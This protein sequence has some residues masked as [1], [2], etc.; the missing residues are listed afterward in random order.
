MKSRVV[1]KSPGPGI[2]PGY[3]ECDRWLLLLEKKRKLEPKDIPSCLFVF[4]QQL[5]ILLTTLMSE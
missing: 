4:T 2:F 5:E 3:N 1:L